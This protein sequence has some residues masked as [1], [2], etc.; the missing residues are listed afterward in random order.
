VTGPI[1]GLFFNVLLKQYG[2]MTNLQIDLE[3]QNHHL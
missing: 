2:T 3:K 1:A